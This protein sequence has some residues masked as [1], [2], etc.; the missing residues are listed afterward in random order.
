VYILQITFNFNFGA[1]TDS[2]SRLALRPCM[3]SQMRNL[4]TTKGQENLLMALA[5]RRRV[6]GL[7]LLNSSGSMTG[8]PMIEYL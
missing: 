1:D 4:N 8:A 3:F 6:I 7:T 5:N 2:R